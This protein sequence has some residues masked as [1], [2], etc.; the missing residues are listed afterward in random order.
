MVPDAARAF[1]DAFG[2]RQERTAEDML[3]HGPES[4]AVATRKTASDRT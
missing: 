1:H 4:P 3:K 2:L